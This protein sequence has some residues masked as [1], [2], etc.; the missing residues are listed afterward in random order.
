MRFSFAFNNVGVE[1]EQAAFCL[2]FPLEP[3]LGMV[4]SQDWRKRESGNREREGCGEGRGRIYSLILGTL[5]VG[6]EKICDVLLPKAEF[7]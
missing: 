7:E 6:S 2:T 5:P 1:T 3:V 4:Y